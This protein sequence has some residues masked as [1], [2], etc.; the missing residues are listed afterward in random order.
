MCVPRCATAYSSEP[1][2]IG[3]G[4]LP[5]SRTTN[6]SPTLLS[7]SSSGPTRLS[8]QASTPTSGVCVFA[9]FWRS[10]VN[11]FACGLPET[12]RWLPAARSC[13]SWSADGTGAES[14]GLSAANRT[15]ELHRR[16][17]RARI[18]IRPSRGGRKIYHGGRKMRTEFLGPEL[19]DG[20]AGAA[21]VL[22]RFSDAGDV[23]VGLEVLAQRLAQ[24]AHAAAM[25]DAHAA[26]A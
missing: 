4:E 15:S 5:A 25:D 24:D 21:L 7:K 16:R 10:A 2:A 6:R 9:H 3:S 11:F 18:L 23:R 17:P 22:W 14:F 20:R 12:K 8:A 26:E 1:T 13:Q 19:D